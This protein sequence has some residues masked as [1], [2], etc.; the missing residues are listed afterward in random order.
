MHRREGNTLTKLLNF[1]KLSLRS[2]KQVTEEAENVRSM[3]SAKEE[4]S[5]VDG[6]IQSK[7]TTSK[8]TSPR[9]VLFADWVML[10]DQKNIPGQIYRVKRNFHQGHPDLDILLNA[11]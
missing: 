8:K 1:D 11:L 10:H 7:S 4:D 3:S 2:K 9:E 5:I 6:E